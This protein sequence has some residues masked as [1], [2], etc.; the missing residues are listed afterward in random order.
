MTINKVLLEQWQFRLSMGIDDKVNTFSY[1]KIDY[2][3]VKNE[4]QKKEKER[5]TER[6]KLLHF[7][8]YM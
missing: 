3:T 1:I 6:K 4:R 7:A 5:T 8:M 2:S